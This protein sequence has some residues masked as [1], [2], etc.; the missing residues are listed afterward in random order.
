MDEPRFMPIHRSLNRPQLLLGAERGLLLFTLMVAAVIIFSA[1]FRPLA[2]LLAFLFWSASFWALT[3]MAK[4]DTM[5][6]KIYQRH[7]RYRSY[8]SAK[9]CV[10][11]Q[12]APLP[13]PTT[14]G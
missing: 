5:M 4:A 10:H 8:Y 3:Q 14:K 2:L 7:I 12:L 13:K 11:A 6:S 1:N 9:G